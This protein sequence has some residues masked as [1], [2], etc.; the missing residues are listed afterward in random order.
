MA[1]MYKPDEPSPPLTPERIAARQRMS[2]EERDVIAMMER[3]LGRVMTEQEEFLSLEQ[4]RHLDEIDE[5]PPDALTRELSQNPRFKVLPR[6]G[7]GFIIGGQ[8]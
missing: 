7:K 1:A 5:P 2:E 6:S 8:R 4:A 3:D